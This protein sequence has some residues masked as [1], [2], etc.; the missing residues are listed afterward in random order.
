MESGRYGKTG[1]IKRH[2][3]VASWRDMK[4]V[5]VGKKDIKSAS[6]VTF[7]YV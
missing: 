7:K 3:G 1:W 6:W 2:K 4:D 5:S